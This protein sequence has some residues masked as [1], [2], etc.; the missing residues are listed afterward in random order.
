MSSMVNSPVFGIN[1]SQAPAANNTST[2]ANAPLAPVPPT[3]LPGASGANSSALDWTEYTGTA[4]CLSVIGYTSNPNTCDANYSPETQINANNVGNLQ[5]SWIFPIPSTLSSP[6]AYTSRVL[7]YAYNGQNEGTQ[8][9]VLSANGIGYVVTNFLNIYGVNLATGAALAK[10]SACTVPTGSS[11]GA[12]IASDVS[13]GTGLTNG[14][15]TPCLGAPGEMDPAFD[16]ASWLS[17]PMAGGPTHQHGWNII[18]VG[19]TAGDV[20][21]IGGWGCSIQGWSVATGTLV[22]NL[23][24]MCG[25]KANPVPG[26][27]HPVAGSGKTTGNGNG[28]VQVIPADNE[29]IF[30]ASGSSEGTGGFTDMVYACS[31]SAALQNYQPGTGSQCVPNYSVNSGGACNTTAG[32]L[33]SSGSTMLWRTF[34]MPAYDG[35]TPN[36]AVNLCAKGHIWIVGVPCSAIEAVNTNII[37]VDGMRPDLAA[38]DGGDP[39]FPSTGCSNAWGQMAVDQADNI[40]A[41]GTGD[42]GPDWNSTLRMGFS[43]LCNAVVGLNLTNGTVMWS[44]KSFTKDINDQDCNLNTQFTVLGK[45]G[46][47]NNPGPLTGAPDNL[48]P[49]GVTGSLLPNGGPVFVKTCK[50]GMTFAVNGLSGQPLWFLDPTM[51]DYTTINSATTSPYSRAMACSP[52]NATACDIGRVWDEIA[53]KVIQ[54]STYPFKVTG[55]SIKMQGT[56]P[57]P[58]GFVTGGS[59]RGSANLDPL[60]NTEIGTCTGV[61]VS[62]NS[63]TATSC[64]PGATCPLGMHAYCVAQ[65]IQGTGGGYYEERYIAETEDALDPQTGVFFSIVMSGPPEHDYIG[66]VGK[67]GQSGNVFGQELYFAG[68]QSTNATLLA[69]QIST[70]Q[71]LWNYTRPIYYRGGIID[72][73]AGGSGSSLNNNGVVESSWPDGHL[74]FTSEATGKVLKDINVGIPLLAPES[75]APD[76]NGV[77]HVLVTYGGVNHGFL[78]EPGLHGP[79]GHGYVTTGAIISYVLGPSTGNSGSG[80][81]SVSTLT[82][83]VTSTNSAG[84]VV[85]SV[86]T[87]TTSV[88][89][90]QSTITSTVGTSGVSSLA[91][92]GAVGVAA[93]LAIVAGALVVLRRRPSA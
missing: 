40:I 3:I 38:Q 61:S 20:A 62:G 53:H 13:K 42:T 14:A 37:Q 10:P 70:G 82:T 24:G 55:G 54:N 56:N 91:F 52:S 4:N 77:M 81:G 44:D 11:L 60:N 80:S 49:A 35:S 19:G 25:S 78:G 8:D 85:T 65:G 28:E 73:G 71:V 6:T 21:W 58:H 66:D 47:N 7:G 18:N 84:S 63:I 89:G 50:S 43:I 41:I 92:Y 46:S 88:A 90:A 2:I 83:T 12:V 29:I 1:N 87:T 26:T 39:V 16:M 32:G 36:F 76:S 75:I 86:V 23:T 45:A 17:Q 27:I 59:T 34:L 79:L 74:I 57:H 5:V 72:F 93:I 31:L 68:L 69:I 15:G 22:A 67:Q 64:N 51:P 33:C 9:A 30:W 48:V